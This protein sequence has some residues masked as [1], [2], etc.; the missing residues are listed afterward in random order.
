MVRFNA[1]SLNVRSEPTLRDGQTN[2]VGS[3]RSGRRVVFTGRAA[4]ADKHLWVE[5]RLANGR[6][7]W[8]SASVAPFKLS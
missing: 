1:T 7:G 8:V 3:L 4:T 2:V 5:I 6:E